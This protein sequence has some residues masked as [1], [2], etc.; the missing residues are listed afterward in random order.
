[1]FYKTELQLPQYPATGPYSFQVSYSFRGNRKRGLSGDLKLDGRIG[2]VMVDNRF[3]TALVI[4]SVLSLLSSVYLSVAVGTDAWYEYRSPPAFPSTDGTGVANGNGN[5]NGNGNASEL[6]TLRDDFLGGGEF[7][8]KMDSDALYRLNGTLGLWRRCI[9][10]PTD[11]HWYRAPDPKLVTECVS[12]S[13]QNQFTPRYREPGNHN[14]EEDILRTYLWR[15][16]FL[17]PLVSLC[18]VLLG[19]VIGLCACACHNLYPTVATGA[20]HLLAA[21]CTLGSVCCFVLGVW[22]LQDLSPLP[23]G[24]GGAVGWSLCLAAVSCP[25]QAMAGALLVW[26]ARTNRKEYCRMRAYRVA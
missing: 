4:G 12:F 6:R 14:S 24:V 17:L 2:S 5:G 25:L 15:C 23:H 7:D 8:E 19:A 16:Q 22:R 9:V 11:Q 21:V 10:V 3:A 26:A 20:L 13:L 18:L 1:M